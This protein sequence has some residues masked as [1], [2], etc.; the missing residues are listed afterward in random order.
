MNQL[1]PSNLS[2]LLAGIE[3]LDGIS[4]ALVASCNFPLA[5]LATQDS[6]GWNIIETSDVRTALES[7]ALAQ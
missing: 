1:D 5:T 7:P 4:N 3:K 2:A 6:E